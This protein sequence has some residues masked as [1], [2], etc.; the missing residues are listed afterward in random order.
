MSVLRYTVRSVAA[1][2]LYM[3]GSSSLQVGECRIGHAGSEDSLTYSTRAAAN[4]ATRMIRSETPLRVSQEW[5]P[6]TIRH[7]VH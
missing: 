6:C 1:A 3:L 7:C 4:D 5:S 2:L